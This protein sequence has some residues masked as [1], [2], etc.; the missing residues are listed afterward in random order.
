MYPLLCTALDSTS[1]I[2]I[3][4]H[5]QEEINRVNKEAESLQRPA[6]D[7]NELPPEQAIAQVAMW[8]PAVGNSAIQMQS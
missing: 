5:F 6:Q 7:E 2:S 1:L 3:L 8:L 4:P